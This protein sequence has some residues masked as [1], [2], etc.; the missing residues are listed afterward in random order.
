MESLKTFYALSGKLLE[1]IESISEEIGLGKSQ[2]VNQHTDL[3]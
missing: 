3:T 1:A 2:I